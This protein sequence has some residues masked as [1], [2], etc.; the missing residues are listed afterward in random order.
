MVATW[1]QRLATV[2]LTLLLAASPTYAVTPDTD[3]ASSSFEQLVQQAFTATN[4]GN[5]AT[6]E[7][8][9]T[10][11]LDRDPENPALWTNRGNARVSQRHLEQ[12]LADFNQAIALAPDAPDPYLNR[13]VALEGLHRW[14]E[15]LADDNQVIARDPEDAMA[16][17]NRGNAHAGLGEW[18]EA[19]ADY[20]HAAELEPKFSFAQANYALTLYQL[21]QTEKA[22]QAMRNLVRRYP[23]FADMRAALAVSLWHDHRHAEAESH[24]VAVEGLDQRYGDRQW[25]VE[26]RRWPPNLVAAWDEFKEMR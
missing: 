15:A 20:R 7:H 5:F 11:L 2:L 22:M 9:W 12:A 8:L 21:G 25:L 13:G 26:E 1:I 6:A 14:T 23:Q 3:A 19:L 24:W 18:E 16:Y 10:Q 17:N 4:Q